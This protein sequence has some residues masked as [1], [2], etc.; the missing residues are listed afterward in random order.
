MQ[1]VYTGKAVATDQN[2]ES[3]FCVNLKLHLQ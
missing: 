1:G 3:I 2:N